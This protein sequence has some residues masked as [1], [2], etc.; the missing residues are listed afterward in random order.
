MMEQHKFLILL[1]YYDRPDIVK[2][3]LNSLNE[4]EYENFEIAF[5]DDGSKHSGKLV[6]EEILHPA[7]LNRVTFYNTNDSIEKKIEQGGSVF[8]KLANDAILNS[9]AQYALML[10][11]IHI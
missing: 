7:I 3:A 9:D 8:G 2:H 10:S 4:L 6:A 11:L 1:F 5:I